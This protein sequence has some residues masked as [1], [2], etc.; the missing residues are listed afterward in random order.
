MKYLELKMQVLLSHISFLMKK[1]HLPQRILSGSWMEMIATYSIL[2]MKM[3]GRFVTKM[4]PLIGIQV[5]QFQSS[6][7]VLVTYSSLVAV[8]VCSLEAEEMVAVLRG[9]TLETLGHACQ[10]D[11]IG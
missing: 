2:E 5:S 8:P 7:L 1:L 4:E 9:R 10:A 3:D 11:L 6:I